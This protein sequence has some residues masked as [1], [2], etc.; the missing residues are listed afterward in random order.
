ML[1]FC[2]K[3]PKGYFPVILEVF[4]LF[5]S[6][7]RPVLKCFFSSFS[8]FFPGF[9]F[10]FPFKISFFALFFV[11]QPLFGKDSLWGFLLSLYF[12][13]SFLKCLLLCLKQFPNVPFLNPKLLLF[14]AFFLLFF[15][16]VFM[17]Y[18]S[19]FLFWCWFCF[20]MFFFCFGGG[21]GWF[22]VVCFQ[23]MKK[24]LSSLQ[25]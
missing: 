12:V 24:T 7:K 22:L 6:P 19:A 3:A 18:V 25:L 14:L 15:V 2:K 23:T 1:V 20:V 10:F 21:G 11:H 16:F 13:F 17:V 4:C 8:V 5:C 9:P